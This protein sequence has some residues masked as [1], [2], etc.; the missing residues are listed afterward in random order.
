[1]TC[2]A[3]GTVVWG[4]IK[5]RERGPRDSCWDRQAKA[6]A[7]EGAALPLLN[8]VTHCIMSSYHMKS[9]PSRQEWVLAWTRKGVQS[10]LGVGDGEGVAGHSYQ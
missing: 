8:Y 1:M 7:P 9:T 6:G 10:S 3:L 2:L 4:G 5:G